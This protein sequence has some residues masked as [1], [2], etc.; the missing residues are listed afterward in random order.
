MSFET[1]GSPLFRGLMRER[2]GAS[3][4]LASPALQAAL[5]EEELTMSGQ[6]P[7]QHQPEEQPMPPIAFQPAPGQLGWQEAPGGGWAPLH[8]DAPTLSTEAI[9][10]MMPFRGMLRLLSLSDHPEHRSFGVLHTFQENKMPP[11]VAERSGTYTHLIQ[12]PSW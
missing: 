6:Q 9:Q 8:R 4:D 7:D 11:L 1:G 3:P 2:Y 12:E 10:E 5:Y